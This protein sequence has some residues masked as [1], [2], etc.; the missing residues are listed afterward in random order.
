MVL[1]SDTVAAVHSVKAG[2]RTLHL[3]S[4][5]PVWDLLSGRKL[6]DALTRIDVTI[7]PP[8]T[9]IY[10]FGEQAPEAMDEPTARRHRE[11]TLG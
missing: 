11:H 4:P 8:E 6:G 2:P 9:R 10:Y 7:A 5:R 1:A 3:P